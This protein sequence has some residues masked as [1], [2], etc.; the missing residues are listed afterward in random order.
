MEN[1]ILFDYIQSIFKLN[2]AQVYFA[3]YVL[4]ELN[5]D[6]SR[7]NYIRDHDIKKVIKD[8]LGLELTNNDVSYTLDRLEHDLYLIDKHFEHNSYKITHSG[9]EILQEHNEL[10]L[11][12]GNDIK[13]RLEEA[14]QREAAL[15]EDM[16]KLDVTPETIEDEI[17]KLEKELI[18]HIEEV[19]TKLKDLDTELQM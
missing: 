1:D 18:E 11:Y 10:L 13:E 17:T 15:I 7:Y 8:Q 19:E 14:K 4:K 9:K 12:F 5:K 3:N 6:Y 2:K 16:K